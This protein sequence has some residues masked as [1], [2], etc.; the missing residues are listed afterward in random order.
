[1]SDTMLKDLR[2]KYRPRRFRHLAQGIDD[3]GIRLITQALAQNR[4][5]LA[6]LL[7]GSY[8]LGKTTLAR[9]LGQRAACTQQQQH[10]YEPCG[11]CAGC[12][13]VIR[14]P[15]DCDL[16]GYSEWDVQINS[17][18]EIISDIARYVPFAKTGGKVMPQRVVFL[19]E[20]HRLPIKHQEKFVKVIE[21]VGPRFKTLF[22]VSMADGAS[23]CAAIAQRATPCR[24]RPPTIVAATQHVRA[25]ARREGHVIHLD[26]AELLAASAAC[27]PRQYLAFLQI[28][29]ILTGD[30]AVVRRE[31]VLAAVDAA[32]DGFGT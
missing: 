12:R 9:L 17:P 8:G 23:V 27:V 4:S 18:G 26:D 13:E 5:L 31:D 32:G 29:L 2:V 25:I 11:R 14:R 1:M 3:P 30:S 16:V 24:L 7:I 22:V 19:D 28:A 20:F 15:H 6:L 10:P 21:D